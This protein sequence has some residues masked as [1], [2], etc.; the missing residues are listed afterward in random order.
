MKQKKYLRLFLF[1]GLLACSQEPD[2]ILFTEQPFIFF[3][4]IPQL[5]IREN[6]TDPLKIP[7]KV[8][9]TLSVPVTVTYEVV[10]DNVVP[11]SDYS[12]LSE[13]PIIIQ[14]GNFEKDILIEVHNNNVIQKEQ[15][16]I[17]VRIKSIDPTDYKPEVVSEVSITVLEDDCLPD[18]A[19]VILWEGDVTISSD[20]GVDDGSAVANAGICG[21]SLQVDGPLFGTNN[22]SSSMIISFLPKATGSDNGIATVANFQPFEGNDQYEYEASGTYNET[23]RQIVLNYTLIF[24]NDPASSFT[25]THTI[26]PK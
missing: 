1:V 9:S 23:T 7:V 15:R 5:D 8:S 18:I 12:V 4:T 19:K 20:F 16:T 17:T 6:A 22:P 10:G 3:D 14:P 2:L 24:V 25:G 26:T 11:G 21:G 13:N